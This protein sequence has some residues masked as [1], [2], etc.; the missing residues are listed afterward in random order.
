MD[1]SHLSVRELNRLA[2]EAAETAQLR[3]K[4]GLAEAKHQARELLKPFGIKVHFSIKP[5]RELAE[6]R[7]KKPTKKV[8]QKYGHPEDRS[9]TWS[10][11]GIKPHWV[12]ALEEEGK[13]PELIA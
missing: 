8:A 12:R 13:T 2:K 7:L 3:Q 5:P 9:K 1:L 11:R 6:K 4:A 10:G